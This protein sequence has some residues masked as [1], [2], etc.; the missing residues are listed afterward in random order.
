[1]LTPSL[2]KQQQQHITATTTILLRCL[3]ACFTG[4][5]VGRHTDKPG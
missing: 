3:F 5:H 4:L 1:M 2:K